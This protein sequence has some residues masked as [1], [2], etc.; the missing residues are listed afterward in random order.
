MHPALRKVSR[1]EFPGPQLNQIFRSYAGELI[2]QLRQH[3]ALN[4]P[5]MPP[6]IEGVEGPRHAKLQDDPRPRNPIG[7]LALNQMTDDIERG[8]GVFAFVCASPFVRQV[9][10]QSVECG[11]CAAQK[12]EGVLQ[13]MLHRT[14][15]S[16][17][18]AVYL[19][20]AVGKRASDAW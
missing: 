4:F 14:N 13:A 8:P 20:I 1:L 2:Q 10:Q 19:I 9:A 15:F 6:A 17:A 16:R 7:A 12:S 18:S 5:H 3:P 11:W